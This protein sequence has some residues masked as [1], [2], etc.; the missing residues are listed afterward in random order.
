MS[1]SSSFGSPLVSPL[2]TKDRTSS[3]V[4]PASPR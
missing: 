4:A 3:A 1:A 2:R